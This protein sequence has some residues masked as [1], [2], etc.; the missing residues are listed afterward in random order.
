MADRSITQKK[1][2]RFFNRRARVTTSWAHISW[3]CPK[4]RC[5]DNPSARKVCAYAEPDAPSLL[6][7]TMDFCVSHLKENI[8][9]SFIFFLLFVSNSG[10]HPQTKRANTLSWVWYRGSC[11]QYLEHS[12]RLFGDHNAC[13]A[14]CLLVFP[15]KTCCLYIYLLC[16]YSFCIW[17]LEMACIEYVHLP[18][19]RGT[20]IWRP[21]LAYIFHSRM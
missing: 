1:L 11:L 10:R 12:R 18:E 7:K 2:T 4:P 5:F 14:F 17:S 21:Y 3:A 13:G 19:T 16:M 9:R 20:C 8:F 6:M 15:F